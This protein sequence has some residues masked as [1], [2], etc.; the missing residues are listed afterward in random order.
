MI[1][2]VVMVLGFRSDYMPEL[3][4][5]S[6]LYMPT[7]LPGVPVREGGVGVAADGSAA[8]G[9]SRGGARIRQAGARRYG[10]RSGTRDDDRD[11]G[12]A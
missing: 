12:T 1:A 7:T 4:E 2:A 11:H 9:H 6:V 3:E 5:G 8:Q 10:H